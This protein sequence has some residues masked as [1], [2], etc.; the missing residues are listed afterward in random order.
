MRPFG[1]KHLASLGPVAAA[2]R[3][4][5]ALPRSDG[6]L[7]RPGIAQ[8][9]DLHF[10]LAGRRNDPSHIMSR[11]QSGL[12]AFSGKV[13]NVEPRDVD[14]R[15]VLGQP[16]ADVGQFDPILPRGTLPLCLL[17]LAPQ[18]R[19]PGCEVPHLF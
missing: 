14:Q 3:Q 10:S 13:A 1:P 11:L 19:L 17:E 9:D 18:L 6:R 5:R 2:C 7:D 15:R 4:R 8:I 16:A 12:L